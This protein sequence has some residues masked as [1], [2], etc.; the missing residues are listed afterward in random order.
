MK[1]PETRAADAILLMAYG[2]PE[3][4]DQVEAYYTDI[5]GGSPPPASLLAELI[6]RYRSIGGGSPLSRVVETQ[7]AAL[8]AEMAARGRATPVYAAMRHTEPRIARVVERIVGDGATHV[9]AIA[10]APQRSTFSAG[11]RRALDAGLAHRGGPAPA[12]TVIDSWHEQPGFIAALAQ[13]TREVL[14]GFPDPSGVLVMFTGHSLPK[15]VVA[16]GDPYP[17]QL[18]GTAALVAGRL[19]LSDYAL[20][21]QS[22]GRTGEAWLGPDLLEEIRRL[23]TIGVRDV[24]VRPVGFVADHLEILYDIDV[25]AQAVARGAGVRLHR[26]RSLNDDPLFIGGLADLAGAALRSEAELADQ[27]AATA[28]FRSPAGPRG[29]RS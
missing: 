7:R 10:L 13:T 26:A 20:A 1:D 3:R 28:A 11:Y 17:D 2:G 23:A 15:R 14:A 4:L 5:R 16:E 21:Y 6:D 22:P 27:P 18:A 29:G 12:V 24:V 9:V 19:G 25:A 8:E